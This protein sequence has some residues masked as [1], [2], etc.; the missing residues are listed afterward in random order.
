MIACGKQ[1]LFQNKT[2]EIYMSKASEIT[3][4]INKDDEKQKIQAN[5]IL[6]LTRGNYKV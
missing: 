1:I 3:L 5:Q 2:D 4:N 6:T